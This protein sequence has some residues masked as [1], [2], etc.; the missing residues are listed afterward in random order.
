LAYKSCD[1]SDLRAASLGRNIFRLLFID[2]VEPLI[3]RN[4]QRYQEDQLEFICLDIAKDDLPTGDCVIL[5]QV[6]HL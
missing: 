5:R 6:L 1:D 4:K 3:K 2:I